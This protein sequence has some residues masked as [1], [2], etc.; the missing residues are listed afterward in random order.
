MLCERCGLGRGDQ[1]DAAPLLELVAP[2][3]TGIPLLGDLTIGRAPGSDLRLEDPSVSRQHARIAIDDGEVRIA[4]IASSHG[5]WVG[6]ARIDAPRP[7][8]GGDE[9]RLGDSVLPVRVR[10]S[11]AVAVARAVPAGA[12]L[13]LPAIGPPTVEPAAERTAGLHPQL[14]EGV[15]VE[16]VREH[17]GA[18]WVIERPGGAGIVRL[19]AEDGR[20]L[21]WFDGHH[22]V[23]ELVVEAE[24]ALGASGP[25]RLARLLADLG[26][27]GLLDGVEG[28]APAV[29]EPASGWR[30]LLRERRWASARLGGAFESLYERGGWLLFTRPMLAAG[31]VLAFVGFAAWLA[32]LLGRYGTPFVV[33]SHLGLG[34]LVFL[35]C[36]LLLVGVHEIA[37]GL[38]LASMGRAVP[39]AGLRLVLI[40]PYAFVD[41]SESWF[42]PRRRRLAVSLSGPACDL[43]LG[44]ALALACRF[45][46]AGTVRDVLFQAA[47]AAYVGAFFNLNPFLERDGYHAL[48]DLLERPKLRERARRHLAARLSGAPTPGVDP[49][50]RRYA[51][52]SLGWS[53]FAAAI[54]IGFS[55]RY[56][57]ILERYAPPGV[58]WGVLA[59]VWLVLLVPVLATVVPPLIARRRR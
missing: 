35:T 26:E 47:L 3:G 36:R 57:P 51:I 27:R 24:R 44:G 9:I 34:G 41:T 56:A 25:V 54:A 18:T 15:R 16:E 8:Q 12:S 22:T 52:A 17:G 20:L 6:D 50:L 2:D 42:E 4:D 39:T 30:R 19:G 33:A 46:P 5:T 38:T 58:V 59:T 7:L 43:A 45:W 23:P 49:A 21:E 31:A 10:R 48:V 1:R 14:R 13:V 32:L 29:P 55:L 11:D 28:A 53:V 40:F 37:H